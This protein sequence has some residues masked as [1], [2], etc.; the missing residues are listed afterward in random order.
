MKVKKVFLYAR[1][2]SESEE[3]QIQS[4]DD[5]LNIMRNKAKIMWLKIVAEFT[6]SMS[7]K[8]PWRKVF[9]AMIAR[10]Q[11]W[12]AEWILSWKID[13]LTRNPMDTGIIQYMLQ[14]KSID[15]IITND[16]DYYPEDS[17]LIFSVESWMANQYILDL[18]KNVQR[19]INS[20]YEKWIR[21]TRAPLG[22]L[23]DKNNQWLAIE[24]SER[25]EVIKKMWEL[26]LSWH[27]TPPK[28]LEI[29]NNNLWL[30]TRVIKTWWWQPLSRSWIYKIFNS[31]FYAG[32]FFHKWELKKWIHKPMITLAEYDIVQ[33]LLWKKGSPRPQNY[34]FSFTGLMRC[35]F[36]W[37]MVTAEIKHKFIEQTQSIKEYIYYHCTRR[38]KNI[39]CN[40]KSITLENLEVQI[41]NILSRIEIQ[42]NFKEWA[43]K[44]LK[45]DS[46]NMVEQRLKLLNNINK[47]L[48]SEERKLKNITDLLLDEIISKEEY[49]EKKDSIKFNIE[50]L[51]T[52]RDNIDLDSEKVLQNTEKVFEF[53]INAKEKFI[54]GSLQDKRE[55]FS[56]LGHNFIL[57]DGVLALKLRPWFEIIWNN[58]DEMNTNIIRFEPTKNSINFSEINAKSSK[59]DQWSETWD[60]NSQ[61]HAPKACALANCASLRFL[62]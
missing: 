50:K 25:F 17:W 26:M 20:K 28:I 58:N 38:N 5:Q 7:A 8:E 52:Q 39:K 1:K 21:P 29:A 34:E 44:V 27:Y 60:S 42:R 15:V 23:N 56:S 36:C 45:D 9:N 4:I 54:S 31:I 30:R 32:Y 6:E 12:E 49:Y 18:K 24:D 16:R 40:Q 43:I 22:Y 47:T 33:K 3:R 2:S 13:R 37:N 61:P 62:K 55:I 11:K 51:K 48:F 53:A 59:L 35:W 14:T 19:W 10:L 57:K 41:L 46:N